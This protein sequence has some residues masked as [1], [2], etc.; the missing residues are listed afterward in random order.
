MEPF[1]LMDL[2][3]SILDY[4]GMGERGDHFFGRSVFRSYDG[5]R[6]RHIPFANVNQNTVG[7]LDPDGH[8]VFCV[9]KIAN[10]TANP[11]T[12]LSSRSVA[13]ATMVA[14]RTDTTL[15]ADA[16]ISFCAVTVFSAGM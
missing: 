5:E 11:A 12:A 16:A 3:L 13:V 14:V 8:L 1:A 10:C 6:G 9:R 2:A 15:Y 4:L 7:T